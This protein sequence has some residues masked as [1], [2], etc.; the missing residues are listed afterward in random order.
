MVQ[1]GSRI[2]WRLQGRVTALLLKIA[3]APVKRNIDNC[4]DKLR[5]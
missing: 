2:P 3:K 1:I 4:A 5:R